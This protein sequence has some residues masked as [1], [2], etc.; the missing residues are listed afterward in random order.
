MLI[1]KTLL[2]LHSYLKCIIQICVNPLL[3]CCS[4]SRNVDTYLSFE[5]L[6]EWFELTEYELSSE[7][8]IDVFPVE[9][10]RII[11]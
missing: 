7:G 6:I 5:A 11:V 4:S 10:F 9:N 8:H 2:R 3:Q 1:T